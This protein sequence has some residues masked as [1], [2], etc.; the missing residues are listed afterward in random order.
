MAKSTVVFD[1]CV[2]YPAPVR[3]L[4]IGLATTGLFRARW[5]EHI[6]DEWVRNLLANR[7]DLTCSQLQRT[8]AL[9]NRAVPDC[10]VEGYE[11]LIESLDL[12]DQDD[13]HV[14]AA[15][16]RSHADLI[17]TFNERDFP[18]NILHKFSLSTEHPDDFV[19]GLIE[20]NRGAVATVVRNQR[21]RLKNP[22]KSVVAFLDTLRNQRLD[23]TAL[24]LQEM[25][26]RL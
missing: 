1:A 14:L 26:D 11:H 2:L 15:A 25:D 5:T 13:R 12:P 23:K 9:M 4:L 10:L 6:H 18:P 8:K 20:M 7:P 24:A 22:P 21:A 3:D 16:I 17:V 19:M